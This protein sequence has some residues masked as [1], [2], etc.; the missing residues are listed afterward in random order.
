MATGK[1]L[2]EFRAKHDPTFAVAQP[3]VFQRALR[4]GCGTFIVVAAQNGTP[5]EADW[6]EVIQSIAKHRKAEILVIPIRYKNPTSQ[7]TASQD[8]HEWWDPKVRDYLW[9]ARQSLNRKIMVLGDF[10]IQ[11]TAGDPLTGAEALSLSQ[12]GIIGHTKLQMKS[13]A[14]P[15]NSMAKILTTTGAVTVENYTDSRA[16]R[17][18][19]FHHSLSCV[20]VEVVG[21]KRFHLRHVHYDK[22]TKSATD[23]NV[24][25]QTNGYGQAPRPLALVMG[26][27]H[28][29]S[30]CPKVERATFGKGGMLDTLRP[31]HL[32]WHDVLDAHSCSPHHKDDPFTAVAKYNGEGSN[33]QAEVNQAIE[34][35]VKHTP[36][37]GLS[38]VVGS[39]H[40][41]MLG[42][43]MKRTDWRLDPENAK[44][45]L[46]VACRMVDQ[47]YLDRRGAN[48]P[49]PF[50]LLVK[51]RGDKR[52]RV[53]DED[54]SFML[55]G[56]ELGMHGHRGPNGSR[57]SIRNLRRIG[58]KSIK[59]H[60]HT[61]GIDE[62]C[63]SCGT[64]TLLRLEYNKGPSSWLNA[65]TVLHEDG[66][67]QI[68]VIVNG[69]WRA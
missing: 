53:L 32:V 66:K 5:V 67:R 22:K 44:F 46:D 42:R 36:K 33:V 3:T 61:P 49:D 14:T 65:H 18:A 41:D 7:W 57:G 20:L 52:V 63:Y 45:Y 59:G 50:A 16:G 51:A 25:Y 68:I 60:D 30:I 43:W 56:V 10:K 40:N 17:I 6:W 35:I 26:D 1:T 47:T 29:R 58:V 15:A 4:K 64:S 55:G 28:V 21:D 9:S 48:Y 34:F 8:N 2:D 19:A 62:G 24:R 27:T 38:V 11:P 13:V 39:N 37:D 23:L 69:D 54:E 12:S 31:K